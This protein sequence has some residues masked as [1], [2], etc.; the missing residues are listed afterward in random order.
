MR[1]SRWAGG[2]PPAACGWVGRECGG[3]WRLLPAG[4][5]AAGKVRAATPPLCGV[6]GC[7]PHPG[8]LTRPSPCTPSRPGCP[9]WRLIGAPCWVDCSAPARPAGITKE[10]SDKRQS[11]QLGLPVQFQSAAFTAAKRAPDGMQSNNPWPPPCCTTFPH[12]LHLAAVAQQPLHGF[13]HTPVEVFAGSPLALLLAL[14]G[15]RPPDGHPV[16]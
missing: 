9:F 11:L 3:R 15:S 16:E 2:G 5:A 1:R 14:N 4:S 6:P 13:G 8:Q 10:Y 7:V 12:P